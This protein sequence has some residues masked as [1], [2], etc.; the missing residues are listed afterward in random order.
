MNVCVCVCVGGGG[1]GVKK[2]MIL[3]FVIYVQ[4]VDPGSENPYVSIPPSTS[5]E[6]GGGLTL[7]LPCKNAGACPSHR[8]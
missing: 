1:G 7:S 4:R 5:Y 6:L 8:S 2:N 3:K